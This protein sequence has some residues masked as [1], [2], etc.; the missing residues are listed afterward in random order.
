VTNRR[1][2]ITD[3]PCCFGG[4]TL[5]R[6]RTGSLSR[7]IV[8][9]KA[10]GRSYSGVTP[11]AADMAARCGVASHHSSTGQSTPVHTGKDGGST[12][13]ASDEVHAALRNRPGKPGTSSGMIPGG[14]KR[15]LIPSLASGRELGHGGDPN[16]GPS[17]CRWTPRCFSG[18][19]GSGWVKDRRVTEATTSGTATRRFG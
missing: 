3:G 19:A 11:G 12:P 10:T 17:A 6:G 13:H 16:A 2:R 9:R 4:T 7:P 14:G 8:S 18:L 1:G 15:S 5:G